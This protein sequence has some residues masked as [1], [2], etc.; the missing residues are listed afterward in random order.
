MEENKRPIWFRLYAYQ[1]PMNQAMPSRALGNALKAAM[2]YFRTGVE[3]ELSRLEQVAYAE[4]RQSVDK[5][6]EEYRV[7][8]A[9][10]KKGGR[11]SRSK[12]S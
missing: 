12:K 2:T 7:Q 11:P 10:G 9:N 3:Q 8:V 6:W 4:F 1:D 5:S